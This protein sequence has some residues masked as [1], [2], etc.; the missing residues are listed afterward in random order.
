LLSAIKSAVVELGLKPEKTALFSGIGCGSKLPHY[1]KTYGFEGLHGRALPVATG[2]KIANRNLNVIVTIGDGDCY[3]IGG[4]HFI[5]AA[6][7]NIDI[8]CI[9]QNNEVYALT[10]GQTSPTSPKGFKSNSTPYGVLEEPINPLALAL[11]AGATYISRGYAFEREHLKALIKGALSHRG[12]ALVDVL[13]PCKP[14]NKVNTKEWY[15]G[16][17]YKLEE[18]GHDPSDINQ[19]IKKAE[20]WGEKIPIGLFYKTQKPT[21]CD[22]LPQMS[23]KPLVEHDITNIDINPLL[24]K[25]R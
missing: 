15:S 19:A 9:V 18:S 3:G 23:E 1:I 24:N 20:E 6:R 13:E 25:F 21:Y 16:R 10:K 4:N 22:G 8:T 5:H 17:L 11:T 14:F 2:A 12:F 7:R